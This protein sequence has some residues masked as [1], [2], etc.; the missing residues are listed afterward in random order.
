MRVIDCGCF[1]V[2][3]KIPFSNWTDIVHAYMDAQGLNYGNLY[4]YFS[5]LVSAEDSEEHDFAMK[6][7]PCARA[8]RDCPAFGD[9]HHYRESEYTDVL[10][11]SNIETPTE[12]TEQDLL[13]LMKKLHR[14]YGFSQCDLYYADVNFF[15]QMIPAVKKCGKDLSLY[16]IAGS[17][18]QLHRDCL[19]EN[20]IYLSVD[21]LSDG[22]LLDSTPYF[23]A[24]KALLPDIKMTCERRVIFDEEDKRLFAERNKCAKSVVEKCVHFF[25]DHFPDGFSQNYGDAKYSCAQALRKYAKGT[26]FTYKKKDAYFYSIEKRT[27]RGHMICLEVA[28]GPGHYCV[29]FE[30]VFKGM[31]FE[32]SLGWCSFSPANQNELESFICELMATVKGLENEM[33]PMLETYYPATPEWYFL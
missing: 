19:G 24:M 12:C 28:A 9:I 30:V 20:Y 25:E 33:L 31:G 5:D 26:G 23:E 8:Q 27:E 14:N 17:G 11:L 4:Y 6:K 1:K 3:T 18:I 15:Q 13:P 29:E 2:K 10:Y 16:K 22:I 7:G 32:H 21:I